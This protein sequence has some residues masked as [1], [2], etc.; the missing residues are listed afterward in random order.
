MQLLPYF[1]AKELYDQFHLDEPWDSEHNRKLI[2]RM[3]EVYR[4]PL[5]AL[6]TGRT[7]YVVPIV[8]KGVFAGR[9]TLKLK[10]ITDGTSNT[11]AVVDADENHAV[12]WTK[13]DD[14]EIDLNDPLKGLVN[15]A[16]HGFLA[17][18]VDGSAR[19]IPSNLD[20]KNL[21]RIFMATDGEPIER[22][23]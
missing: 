13:P 10:E 19:V 3:P 15:D 7:T 21:G 16:L 18:Y 23:W 20:K 8:G 12:V 14:I 2:D 6:G 17:A 22:W 1:G 11:I 9:D 4:S 5:A